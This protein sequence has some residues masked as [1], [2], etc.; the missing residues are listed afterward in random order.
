MN[1]S[2]S[3][4]KDVMDT[5]REFRVCE[6]STIAKDGTPIT[7]PVSAR[8]FPN[9]NHFLLTTSISLPA[10]ANNIC[11]NSKVGM[12]FS[13]PTGSGLKN[14][15]YVMVKGNASVLD[16]IHTSTN[17]VEGL[18][19]YWL[20][21]IYKRQPESAMISGNPVMRWVMDWYYMRLVIRVVPMSFKWWTDG[22]MKQPAQTMEFD[23]VG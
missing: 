14:P 15:P 1:I 2:E 20:E 7:W 17:S 19:E 4:P 11:R 22:E 10:K 13:D 16:G 3:L 12:L 23:H 18:D 5:I 6:F 9:K 21:S 8:F